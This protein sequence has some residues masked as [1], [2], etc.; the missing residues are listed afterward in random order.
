MDPMADIRN[1]FFQEC[2]EQLTALEEGLMAMDEGQSSLE[3]INSVFRAVHSVKGGAGAFK[4]TALVEFAHTFETVLD[5]L[6]SQALSADHDIVKALLRAADILSDL[7]RLCKEGSAISTSVYDQSL[8]ELNDIVSRVGPQ[9]EEDF[10]IDFTPS[11]I[12]FGDNEE[13]DTPIFKISFAPR[14]RLYQNANDPVTL[15]RDLKTFGDLSVTARLTRCPDIDE[16]DPEDSLL[17]FSAELKSSAPPD[18]IKA[19]FEFVIDDCNLDISQQ[20]LATVPVFE[21][22]DDSQPIELPALPK[23]IT[24]AVEASLAEVPPLPSGESSMPVVAVSTAAP[25]PEPTTDSKSAAAQT[26]RVDLDRVDRLINLVGELVINQAMMASSISAAGT[27]VSTKVNN[28]LQELERLTRDIQDGVMTIRAQPAKSLFQRMSRIVR[29]VASNTGKQ[30]RLKTEGEGTEIDK[31][32]IDLLADPLTHMIRN[33]VDHGLER[34]EDRRAAG[35]P[36]EGVVRLAAAHRSGKVV[37]TVADDGA[38]INRPRVLEIAKSKGLIPA[39]AQLSESEIDGLLFLPGFSTAKSVSSISGRGVGMDVVKRSIQALGGRISIS[40]IPGNG[41]TFTLG[42]PLTLAVLDGMVVSVSDQT[43]VVPVTT[44]IETLKPTSAMLAEI[45]LG[46]YVIKVRGK[47]IPV[48]DVGLALDVRKIPAVA[49]SCVAILVEGANNR[50][51]ALLVDRILDQRQVVIKSMES[52]YGAV[53]GIAAAT[54]LGD[55][56]VAMIVDVDAI[57]DLPTRAT[58]VY[59]DFEYAKAG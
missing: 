48:V 49:S 42:L 28:N 58:S 14:A 2:E 3:T 16:F 10:E 20:E 34:P 13:T 26:I 7:V 50:Q 4:L 57:V 19:V 32:V 53:K 56:R 27:N 45:G 15:F 39:D 40:S 52:N 9:D 44:V 17:A 36:E 8:V 33:A 1:T 29:E 38:G 55:G 18:D 6:R 59:E 35:K 51:T 47:F 46:N 22:P 5:L 12:S 54:I 31:T 43:F 21:V 25:T 37:I 24:P 23:F 11:L 41:T 30:V